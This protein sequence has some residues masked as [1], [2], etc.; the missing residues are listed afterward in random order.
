MTHSEA[1]VVSPDLVV[2]PA[3]ILRP[4][5]CPYYAEIPYV[6]DG[7]K[8]TRTKHVIFCSDRDGHIGEHWHKYY[9]S[10]TEKVWKDYRE[11]GAG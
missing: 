11:I 10:D 1:E 6:I 2:E 7:K 3:E 5:P 8:L 9:G 4:G